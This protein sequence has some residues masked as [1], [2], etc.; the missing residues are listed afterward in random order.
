MYVFIY[1]FVYVFIYLFIYLSIYLFIYIFTYYAC[2]GISCICMYL[3]PRSIYDSCFLVLGMFWGATHFL[4][5]SAIR[6]SGWN[7]GTEATEFLSMPTNNK[8]DSG[9]YSYIYSD[10]YIYTVCT[11]I[12]YIYTHKSVCAHVYEHIFVYICHVQCIFPEATSWQYAYSMP[13]QKKVCAPSN[14]SPAKGLLT[15]KSID[16]ELKRT[17]E[18]WELLNILDLENF[19]TRYCHYTCYYNFLW[20]EILRRN[21]KAWLFGMA[22]NQRL[23]LQWLSYYHPNILGMER[24]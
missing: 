14:L 1:L 23:I 10:I 19:Q 24:L 12:I 7:A 2:T 8:G 11:H 15:S 16:W 18:C 22:G 9:S 6:A 4:K 13:Q 3:Y 20:W 17:L 5:R 21:Q